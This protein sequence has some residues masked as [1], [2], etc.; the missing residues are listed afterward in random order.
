[1]GDLEGADID[2]CQE[3]YLKRS[4]RDQD[5]YLVNNEWVKIKIRSDG[6]PEVSILALSI[7][8]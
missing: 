3:I 5:S 2:S 6:S 8:E 7:F 1:M 4:K